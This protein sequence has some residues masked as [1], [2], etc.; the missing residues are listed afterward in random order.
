MIGTP[1]EYEL[2]KYM[3]QAYLYLNEK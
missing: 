2:Y 1:I 3:N